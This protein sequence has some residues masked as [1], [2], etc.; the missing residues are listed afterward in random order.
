[1]NSV[2]NWMILFCNQKTHTNEIHF[3]IIVTAIRKQINTQICT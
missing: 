3:N 1:M 2:T